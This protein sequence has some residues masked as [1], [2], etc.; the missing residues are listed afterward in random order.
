VFRSYGVY[1]VPTV[2]LIGPD[3]KVVRRF[4]PAGDPELDKVVARLLK[5]AK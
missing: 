5:D 3:G 4:H 2:V 1:A